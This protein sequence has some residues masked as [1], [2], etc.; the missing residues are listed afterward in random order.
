MNDAMCL[1]MQDGPRRSGGRI[2]AAILLGLCIIALLSWL[3]YE[4]RRALQQATRHVQELRQAQVELAKGF[5]QISLAGTSGSSFSQHTGLAL[6]QQSVLSFE[7]SLDQLGVLDGVEAEAFRRSAEAF[8]ARLAAWRQAPATDQRG[9]VALRIAFADLERRTDRVDHAARR[10]IETLNAHNEQTYT[11]SLLGS[12]LSLCLIVGIILK[13]TGDERRSLKERQKAL[14]LLAAIAEST[15]DAIFAKDNEGRY[16]LFNRAASR[17][18][19]KSAETMLG[20]DDRDLFPAEQAEMLMQVGRQVMRQERILTQEEALDT[21]V[22]ARVFLAT[23]GPLRDGEGR[24]IGIFGISRDITEQ[25]LAERE[26]ERQVL[27]LKAAEEALR[28]LNATLEMRVA[29]RTAELAALNQSLESFVY[30]TSHDLKAPLRGIEGYSRLLAEDYGDRL[31]DE[32]RLFIANICNGI[33]RMH[34]LIDDLLTYSRMERC[35]LERTHVDLPSL[36][37]GVLAERREEITAR[38]VA[39]VQAVPPLAVCADVEGLQLVLRNLIENAL[40]FS[41]EGSAPRIE[42]GARQD[43]KTV[44]LWI[45]DSGIGFDMKYHE[46]IF[47]IFQRLHRLEDY[48]GTGIGLA[49]VKKAMQ[50]MGGRVWAESVPGQGASFYVQLPK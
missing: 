2:V 28:E 34:E 39:V 19:G 31:N 49:L 16:L 38:A 23:K 35:K 50:R 5:L 10:Y 46:R 27:R 1:P 40:K 42:I 6:L 21:A 15:E 12:V 33:A 4:Q 14:E 3:H 45:S 43:E 37:A 25:K 44:T 29:E 20:R 47:E 22:G 26:I 11:F 32:G 48:P 18:V 8:R 36:V 9:L 7:R 30:S 17:F 41:L 13:I 24:V